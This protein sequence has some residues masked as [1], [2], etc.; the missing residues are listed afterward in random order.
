MGM[1]W[2]IVLNNSKLVGIMKAVR[3]DLKVFQNSWEDK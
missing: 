3:S 1:A 2:D